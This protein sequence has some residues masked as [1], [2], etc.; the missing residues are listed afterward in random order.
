[1]T[2]SAFYPYYRIQPNYCDLT[3]TENLMRQIC[4]YIIDAPIE[5]YSPPDDNSYPRCRLWKY[6]YYD[7]AQP[8][9]QPLPTINQKMSVLYNP[10]RATNPPTDKGYR[11]FIQEYTNEAQTNG[12]TR[13][14]VYPGRLIPS[15]DN[16]KV[17]ISINFDIWTNTKYE[18]NLKSL[19]NVRTYQIAVELLKA[20]NGL[21]INGV[22]TFFFS[23]AKHPDCGSIILGGADNQNTGRQLTIALELATSHINTETENMPSFGKNNNIKYV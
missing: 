4:D 17:S 13:I 19:E 2:Y 8:L 1:M 7:E 16:L 23:R 12:Q 3:G 11:L 10:D 9:N 14:Y 18:N 15:E 21:S 5:D 6:L 22:G 20:F